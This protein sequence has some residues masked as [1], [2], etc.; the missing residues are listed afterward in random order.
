MFGFLFIYWIWKAFSNL[1]IKFNRNKWKYFF[2]GLIAYY[3]ITFITAIIYVVIM[4]IING[5]DT[6]NEG[7]YDNAGLNLIFAVFG[8]VGC[9]GVYKFLENKGEKEKELIEK[10]GIETIGLMEE[11]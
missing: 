7:D 8:G 1:A 5:F 6:L 4:G 11:N 2:I 3:G 9:Y 10:E